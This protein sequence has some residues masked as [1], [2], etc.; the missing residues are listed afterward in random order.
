[1]LCIT[2]EKELNGV[3]IKENSPEYLA[4]AIKHSIFTRD[5]Y[6]QHERS[7]K[8]TAFKNIISDILSNAGG[9]EFLQ[10]LMRY[11]ENDRV[12]PYITRAIGDIKANK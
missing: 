10:G 12:T 5:L 11:L 4:N 1:M 6:E 8:Y 2:S 7:D 3:K 9:Y